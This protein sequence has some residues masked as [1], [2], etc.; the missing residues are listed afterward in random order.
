MAFNGQLRANYIFGAIYNMII[1]QQVAADNL[2]HNYDL[3][4]DFKTD[5]SLYGDTKLFYATDVLKTTPW[6]NDAEA[7]NLLSLNR[8]QAPNCQAVTLSNFR[9]ISL[10]VDN[11]LSKQ[12][13]A[14]EGAFSQ[15]TSIMLGWMG[16]TKKM[17]EARLFNT[18]IGGA[19][20]SAGKQL[21]SISVPAAT[22]NTE[23]RMVYAENVAEGI[24]NLFTELMDYSREFNDLGYMRSYSPDQLM[25]IWNAQK[26]NKVKKVSLPTMYH[27]DGL[28]DKFDEKELPAKY[29]NVP[30]TSANVTV[31]S[32][33]TPTTGKPINSS[34]NAYT[35]GANHVNGMVIALVEGDY[36]GTAGSVHCFPGDEIP[37]GAVLSTL[38]TNANE[39]EPARTI[40]GIVDDTVICKI[41]AK[42]GIP[43]MSAFEVA[44]SF[45]NPKS[46]TTN[47]YLTFGYSDL[48]YLQDK[49]FITVKE[50]RV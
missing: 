2:S 39:G 15:F 31:Y 7:S 35:P 48:D 18:Y 32:A 4:S 49:P 30:I 19:Q 5:G 50:N 6:L 28:I 27:K 8:P 16:E 24:A 42:N 22:P 10:T 40:Y 44:T 20:T 14:D 34:T 3:V 25:V 9:Q 33:S 23:T 12:A 17:Y 45:F 36:T 43:F 21:V 26:K 37:A 46:L 47:H 13:W 1:S 41:V 38:T 11:Y 29:F